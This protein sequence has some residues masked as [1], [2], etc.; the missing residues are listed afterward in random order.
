MTAIP[1]D[2]YVS[3][4]SEPSRPS[5]SQKR[6]G[7]GPLSQFD[8]PF[9]FSNR[10]MLE[11]GDIELAKTSRVANDFDTRDLA[12]RAREYHCLRQFAMR[13]EDQSGRSVNEGRL[14]KSHTSREC[15]ELF[16]PRC[17]T[18]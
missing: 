7:S 17:S 15:N 2:R 14:H 1:R 18:P 10:R 12:V 11:D 8:G 3:R 4:P 16:R 5:G 9:C 6:E 13:R